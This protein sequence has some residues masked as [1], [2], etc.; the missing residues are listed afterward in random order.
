VA[1][2]K[3][4]KTEDEESEIVVFPAED[5][6]KLGMVMAS[7]QMQTFGMTTEEARDLHALLGRAL[8]WAK[9]QKGTTA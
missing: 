3:T 9:Q 5:E 7:G 1:Y 4:F 8:R 6:L 2:S